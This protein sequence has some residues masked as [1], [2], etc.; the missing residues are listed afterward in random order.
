MGGVELGQGKIGFGQ[1]ELGLDA[2]YVCVHVWDVDFGK[3]GRSQ[4]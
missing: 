4:Q 1:F 2:A 3:Q